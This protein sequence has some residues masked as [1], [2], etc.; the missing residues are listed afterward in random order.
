MPLAPSCTDLHRGMRALQIRWK[1]A[2]GSL[3]SLCHG[4]AYCVLCQGMTLV[5]LQIAPRVGG[6]RDRLRTRRTADLSTP[7]RSGRDDNSSWEMNIAFPRK[8]VISTGAQRSGE[9]CS[10]TGSQAPPLEAPAVAKLVRNP[11]PKRRAGAQSPFEF[12]AVCG[13]TE[14]V[15]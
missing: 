11:V 5:V 2:V 3:R 12:W 10:S 15:P 14:V 1:N 7:L 6:F 4:P 8:I 9:I 13:T